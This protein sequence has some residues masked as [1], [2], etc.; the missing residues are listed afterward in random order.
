MY[1]NPNFIIVGAAKCGTTSLARYL[2]QHPDVFIHPKKEPR[3]F[4]KDT[5]RR[6]SK[7]DP[8]FEGV[9]S[10]TV[11]DEKTY[12]D[13]FPR[14]IRM[15]GEASVHYLYHYEE[16][17][18]S[19]KKYVG[20]IPIIILLR[21]PIERAI[22][23]WAYNAR[24]FDSFEASIE[25]E[26]YRKMKGYNS[27]WFYKSLGL[28]Y[29]QV[30]AY[31]NNFS[32]TKVVIYDDFIRDTARI[33]GDVFRFLN[34]DDNVKID[35]GKIHNKITIYSPKSVLIKK[36]LQ[37]KLVPFKILRRK[38]QSGSLLYNALFFQKTKIVSSEIISELKEFYAEDLKK[39]R[40][41]LKLSLDGWCK[42]H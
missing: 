31:K 36:A 28:Y 29:E 39:L 11:F 13:I 15:T 5:I 33:V 3:F 8:L 12:F 21:D 16:S 32:K 14:E 41:L 25:K 24:D 37:R 17:I 40:V 20:D 4:I 35:T 22:S 1:S 26:Q 9:F 19:I 7:E 18:K 30:S 38:T 6:I 42:Q 2:E 27:F 10:G 34:L 23:N